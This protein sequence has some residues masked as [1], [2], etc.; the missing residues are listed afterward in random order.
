[1]FRIRRPSGQAL[2]GLLARLEHATV[3]YRE[4]GATRDAVLPPGYRHDRYETQIASGRTAYERGVKALR[5]WQAQRGAGLAVWPPEA[6]TVEGATALLLIRV[7]PVWAVAPSRVV[8]TE[9]TANAFTFAYGT[10]PGH[11]E[12]GEA[13]F[14]VLYDTDGAVSL[15][16]SSFSQPADPLARL[17]APL[18]RRLQKRVTLRYVSAMRAASID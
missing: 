17:G 11:P 5:G 16:I 6:T 13:A 3:T 14:A 12:R 4:V 18:A 15:R 2:D 7:G 8:Y 9:E 10:L 1:V